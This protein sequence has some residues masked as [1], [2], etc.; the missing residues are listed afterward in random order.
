MLVEALEAMD[1]VAQLVVGI[2][3]VKWRPFHWTYMV[4][5]GATNHRQ[6]QR[7][8]PIRSVPRG[9]PPSPEGPPIRKTTP[10]PTIWDEDVVVTAIGAPRPTNHDGEIM[11]LAAYPR[12]KT[13]FWKPVGTSKR[14][15]INPAR[16]EKCRWTTS[17]SF[18]PCEMAR[19]ASSIGSAA[20]TT[21]TQGPQYTGDMLKFFNDVCRRLM[22]LPYRGKAEFL[23]PTEDGFKLVKP[24][25]K[26]YAR[27]LAAERRSLSKSTYAESIRSGILQSMPPCHLCT[28]SAVCSM[29]DVSLVADELQHLAAHVPANEPCY[30][31]LLV[32][33]RERRAHYDMAQVLGWQHT[34]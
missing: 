33:V 7:N 17:L 11:L 19:S 12:D 21:A 16:P 2:P 1:D 31:Q 14:Q 5:E 27:K 15:R 26:R 25:A 28:R 32:Y 13:L 22:A 34:T 9:P 20:L 8:A 6:G 23:L 18:P 30:Q 3:A 24:V 10:P 4:P 29:A